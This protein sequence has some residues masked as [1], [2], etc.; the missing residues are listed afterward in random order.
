[1][2]RAASE[3]SAFATLYRLHAPAIQ[4]YLKRRLGDSH[5]VEDA[6]AETFV[7][8]LK[9]IA[10]YQ[11]RGLPFRSWLYRIATGEAHRQY[12]RAQRLATASLEIE[13][14]ARCP[15][16]QPSAEV[17][18]AALL[19]IAPRY[20]AVLALHYFEG[21]SVGET[22]RALKCREGTVKSRLS[23][24]REALRI[25]LIRMGVTS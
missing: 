11:D 13:P 19:L 17:A 22:A 4:R 15:V 12:K 10:R 21:L 25:Q 16:E 7:S 23:R 5:L 1:M 24:G 2:R 20:Q 9:Q 14:S 3:P 18:R 6:V 8:A